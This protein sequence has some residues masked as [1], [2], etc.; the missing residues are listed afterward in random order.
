MR[1]GTFPLETIPLTRWLSKSK[2]LRPCEGQCGA[3]VK[4]GRRYCAPYG[5]LYTAL[6]KRERARKAYA[7]K[8]HEG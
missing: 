4:A 6:K 8:A 5:D 3:L 2:P 7:G 1:I